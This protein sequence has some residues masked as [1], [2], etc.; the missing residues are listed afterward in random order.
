MTAATY[1]L[2]IEQ[3]AT[4]EESFVVRDSSNN[5]MDLTGYTARMQIRPFVSSPEVLLD[6][7]TVNGILVITALEGRIDLV[8]SPLQTEQLLYT[9]SV[10]DLEIED[11][12]GKVTRLVQGTV[13]VSQQVTRGA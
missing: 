10:Y 6:A 8:L 4:F 7:S 13:N 11:A 1:N 3:G 9:T 2:N 12:S 5:L